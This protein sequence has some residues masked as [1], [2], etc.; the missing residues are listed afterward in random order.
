[1]KKETAE[2]ASE[3]YIK[4]DRYNKELGKWES[5]IG[6]SDECHIE[7]CRNVFQL[8]MKILEDG[9]TFEYIREGAIRVLKER[10]AHIEQEIE[11]LQDE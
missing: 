3:L 5:A 10:I 11:I 9:F 8:P 6:F 7:L 2:K 1:M 4:L